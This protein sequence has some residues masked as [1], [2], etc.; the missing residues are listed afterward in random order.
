MSRGRL[1]QE[2]AQV[3]RVL[4][5]SLAVALAGCVTVS[6]SSIGT[7]AGVLPCGDCAGVL[8]E[9]RLY[10]EQPSGR[11]ARYE[12]TE[13]YL[14]ALD[15]RG[16]IGTTGRWEALR[17]SAGD[18]DA[19]VVQL[20]LGRVGAVKNFARVGDDELRFLDRN[21][22]EILSNV[23]HSLHRVLDLPA[24]T[25]LESDSGQTIEV[26]R[27]QRVFVVLGVNRATGYDWALDTPASG[28]LT[29]LSSPV[30]VQEAA[31]YGADGTAMW[32]FGASGIGKQELVFQ[33]RRPSE[34]A[35]PAKTV[36][37]T[38]TVR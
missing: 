32:F 30:Y 2:Q 23:P 3:K 1:G 25:L 11:A 27:G 31:A 28:P 14:G 33:Y 34:Q 21:K 6:T 20:D 19:T 36:K 15:G 12:L 37:F 7:F 24:A 29:S 26:E 38:I 16:S 9:L 13:T 35:R 8:T 10:A 22:R 5:L 18:A 4:A 17:G